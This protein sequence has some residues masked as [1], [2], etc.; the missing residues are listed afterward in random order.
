M[1]TLLLGACS[2]TGAEVAR[3]PADGTDPAAGS[4]ATARP[5]TPPA[6]AGELRT[7]VSG[8]GAA[9]A[10]DHV[11]MVGDSVLVLV[12]DDVA[13]NLSSELHVDAA[14][15]RRI[16]ADVQGPCGAVPAGTLVDDGIDAL[17]R[18][19]ADLA[20]RGVVPEAAV[21]VLANNSSLTDER[22]DEAMATVAD[23]GR[24]W[25]VTTRIDGFGRQDPNNRA[26]ADL[27]ARDER[28]RVIDWYA[29]SEGE[30][31]LADH[32]HPNDAGQLA[33][34]RLIA[35]HVACDCVP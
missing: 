16:D 23:I 20:A 6:T 28:A 13:A 10:P 30:P 33:L 29:A 12:A 14:D 26:L 27:A 11:L 1:V 3:P 2:T 9:P 25:W 22:L 17:G 31:W 8:I 32:V 35:D 21:V 34:G 24:V 7:R 4:T 19:H 15:C 5:I 18:E